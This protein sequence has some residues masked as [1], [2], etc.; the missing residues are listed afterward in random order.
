MGENTARATT[1]LHCG[2]TTDHP[3]LAR[4]VEVGAGPGALLHA[5]DP[6]ARSEYHRHVRVCAVCRRG[7]NCETAESAWELIVA[8]QAAAEAEQ[9]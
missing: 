2:R 7:V 4:I 9:P 5:C 6:C 3:V 8:A 1:C